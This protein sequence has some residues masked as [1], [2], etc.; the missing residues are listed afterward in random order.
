MGEL[1]LE[2]QSK[3]LRVIQ[4][5][6]LERLGGKRIKKV[7]VRV[8]AATNRNLRDEVRAGRFREDLYY[9]LNVFP[10]EIPP[11]RDRREDIPALAMS[12]LKR[13]C[14]SLGRQIERIP[15]QTMEALITYDWPGNIREL[16]N[17]I[18]R[19]IILSAGPELLLAEPLE[20]RETQPRRVSG[21]LRNDLEE[22]ERQQIVDAL[23][24]SGWKIKGEGNAA[25]RLGLKP[26]TLRSRMKRLGIERH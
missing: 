4:D 24:A 10:V 16:Q 26:S 7:D 13:R 22:L 6:E 12:F 5:G 11:L 14:R 8:I 15:T 20:P 25:S 18:E 17:V 9:R 2:L 23:Q 19:A 1:P 21:V 3:L